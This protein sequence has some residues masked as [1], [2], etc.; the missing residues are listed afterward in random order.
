MRR[1]GPYRVTPR[2]VD[3]L[4]LSGRPG[5]T[6]KSSCPWA[7]R[8][9][10]GHSLWGRP[11]SLQGLKRAARAL[12]WARQDDGAGLAQD[13]GQAGW[14]RTSPCRLHQDR[15]SGLD[16]DS[17]AQL[18]LHQDRTSGLDQDSSAQL[19]LHQD[20]T[21]RWTRRP[22]APQ[23]PVADKDSVGRG[24]HVRADHTS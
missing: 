1:I 22:A 4:G 19:G 21:S 2:T 24:R 20:R 11:G 6:P 8:A 7:Y 18:G 13:T 5:Y 17:S 3:G 10:P 14:L 12:E 16:Q 15:T 9:D 23:E